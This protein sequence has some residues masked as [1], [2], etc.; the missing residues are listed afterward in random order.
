M[1]PNH[2]IFS[3]GQRPATTLDSVD[4]N[5]NSGWQG[6]ISGATPPED[7]YPTV[8]LA[9]LNAADVSWPR[10]KLASLSSGFGRRRQSH[11]TADH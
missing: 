1:I 4:L 2:D 9:H 7:V 11:R 3:T 5:S 8:E 10:R 6:L